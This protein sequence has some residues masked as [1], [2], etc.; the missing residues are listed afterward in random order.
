[1]KV[2][3]ESP[4][5]LNDPR[6][7]ILA[8]EAAAEAICREAGTD[9]ADAAMMLLTA[10]VHLTS[11]H[12]KVPVSVMVQTLAVSLGHATVAADD[13]FKLRPVNSLSQKDMSHG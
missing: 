4:M 13:L 8:I 12:T 2:S 5:G 6:Q 3:I 11:R 7:R 9:P 10:A 1:M